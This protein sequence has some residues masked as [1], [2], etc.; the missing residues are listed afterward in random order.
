MHIHIAPVLFGE[1]TQ[2]FEHIGT[3]HIELERTQTITTPGA[4][5]LRFRVL[6]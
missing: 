5:H 2:L 6:K 3:Q 4:T 1:G